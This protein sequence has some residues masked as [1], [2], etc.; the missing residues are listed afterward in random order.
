[1]VHTLSI[2]VTSSILAVTFSL[3]V[4]HWFRRSLWQTRSATAGAPGIEGRETVWFD[5]VQRLFHWSVTFVTVALVFTG[6][7]LYYPAYVA[8]FLTS[9]GVPVHAFFF[10]WIDVHVIGA[11]ILLGLIV[12]HI[13]WDSLKLR[14]TKLMVPNREDV[15]EAMVRAW[16]FV[17]GGS[18]TPRSNKY[19]VFMKSYHALLIVCSLGLG[20]TGVVQYVLAPWWLYPEILHLQIE[21]WWKPTI[22]HDLFGFIL[23]GLVVGHTYFSVLKVNRPLLKA[24]VT[25]TIARGEATRGPARGEKSAESH[26]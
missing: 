7:I 10:G 26:G 2:V 16:R 4:V 14:T 3:Y 24:M 21:P 18:P 20:V 23:I 25:G 6:L 15:R 9:L 22:L 11:V 5:R 8:P 1:M 13:A 19:D 12:L 17:W